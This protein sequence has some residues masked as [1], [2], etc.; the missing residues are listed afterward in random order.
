MGG[1]GSVISAVQILGFVQG[2]FFYGFYHG[3][4]PLF[5]TMWGIYFCSHHRTSKSPRIKDA[6]EED[7]VNQKPDKSPKSGQGVTKII[8][9]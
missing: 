4:S 3:K 9:R 2:V 6:S 1:L 8:Y 7:D 5:T